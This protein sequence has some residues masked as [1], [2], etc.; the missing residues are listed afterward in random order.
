[1][2]YKTIVQILQSVNATQETRQ[3]I[4]DYLEQAI[5][6]GKTDRNAERF[7][8]Y[9]YEHHRFIRQW[10]TLEYAE[11]YKAFLETTLPVQSVTVTIE[12]A[13]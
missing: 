5:A 11:Q 10:T 1:M 4:I 6:D 3:P 8:F 7:F 2:A 13:E 9:D 12:P